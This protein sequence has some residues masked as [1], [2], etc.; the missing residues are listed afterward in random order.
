MKLSKKLRKKIKLENNFEQRHCSEW[1][2]LNFGPLK[3]IS[4]SR[5][6]ISGADLRLNL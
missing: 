6:H 2:E 4:K 3:T 1:L 5:A